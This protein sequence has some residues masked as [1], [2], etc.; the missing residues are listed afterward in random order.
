MRQAARSRLR[1]PAP[2]PLC[3]YWAA[4]GVLVDMRYA[5]SYASG[6]PIGET[7]RPAKLIIVGS[8]F[9]NGFASVDGGALHVDGETQCKI[10][11]TLIVGNRA[12]TNG[13]AVSHSGITANVVVLASNFTA[14][15]VRVSA[16][17]WL[18]VAQR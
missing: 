3:V 14:N 10:K 1:R 7:G 4:D 13:G 12:I 2:G 5:R 18:Q 11:S 9:V 16:R 6:A 17:C 8:T 15:S